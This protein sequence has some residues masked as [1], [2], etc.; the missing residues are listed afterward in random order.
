VTTTTEPAGLLAQ[1]A[2]LAKRLDVTWRDH[3]TGQDRS[4][5]A[6]IEHTF[7]GDSDS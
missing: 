7:G 3:D 1:I 5:A 6:L 4:F 2:D